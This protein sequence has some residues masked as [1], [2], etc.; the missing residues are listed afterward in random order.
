MIEFKPKRPRPLTPDVNDE[1]LSV[2]A[3]DEGY[4]WYCT[5]YFESLYHGDTEPYRT[6]RDAEFQGLYM[7]S[8]QLRS[9]LNH[10]EQL[11]T[12]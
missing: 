1:A 2:N 9:K 4:D 5:C 6:R 3:L 10:S 8:M 12:A 7:A 11:R